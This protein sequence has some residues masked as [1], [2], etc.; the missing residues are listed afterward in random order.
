MCHE[1]KNAAFGEEFFRVA[2]LQSAHIVL[3]CSEL[4][5]N[6]KCIVTVFR[7]YSTQTLHFAVKNK[8]HFNDIYFYSHLSHLLFYFLFAVFTVFCYMSIF[9]RFFKCYSVHMIL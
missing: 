6:A 3:N 5:V 8:A 1:K 9:L 2:V 4:S 7:K